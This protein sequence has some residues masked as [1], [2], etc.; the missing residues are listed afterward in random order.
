MKRILA[1][2]VGPL[3]ALACA[4]GHAQQDAATLAEQPEGDAQRGRLVFGPCR[5]CH[6]TDARAGH[7][8]GPNLYRIFGKVAGKQ[9]G[10]DYYSEPLRAA[11][12]VWTPRVLDAWLAAPMQ[13]LPGT[14][15]MSPGVPDAA[16]RADLIAYLQ[17]VSVRETDDAGEP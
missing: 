9:A 6:F 5:S 7:G 4:S 1:V 16:Q 14:T 8:N 2:L 11:Q 17:L 3:L 13:V 12:F 10:F 15:M